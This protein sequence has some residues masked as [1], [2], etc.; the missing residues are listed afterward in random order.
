MKSL[1]VGLGNIGPQYLLTRHNVGFMALDRLAAGFQTSFKM[2]R[3]AYYAEAK[4]KGH[5]IYFDS[6]IHGFARW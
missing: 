1:I 3:L 2:D 6:T 5:Q 4:Y